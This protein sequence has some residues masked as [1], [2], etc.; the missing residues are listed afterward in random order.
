[1]IFRCC[2]AVEIRYNN[3]SNKVFYNLGEK[4]ITKADIILQLKSQIPEELKRR[5]CGCRPKEEDRE[6][7]EVH[8]FSYISH[9]WL[10]SWTDS[11]LDLL[12]AKSLPRKQS[13]RKCAV[14]YPFRDFLWSLR[15]DLQGNTVFF[16]FLNT[17]KQAD[18]LS[19][20]PLFPVLVLP[21]E[22]GKLF[23][24]TVMSGY[25][26]TRFS[27]QRGLHLLLCKY[28]NLSFTFWTITNLCK[29]DQC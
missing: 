23:L 27:S 24:V 6:K 2:A 28:L 14:K 10:T 26:E 9:C 4:G 29:Q 5:H 16:F 22:G 1:M 17:H 3:Y 19:T 7:K 20:T 21:S 18:F 15:F 8:P 11:L 12:G 25:S 13:S